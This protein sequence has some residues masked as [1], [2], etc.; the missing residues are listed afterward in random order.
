MLCAALAVWAVLIWMQLREDRKRERDLV[1]LQLLVPKKESK[2]DK[3]VESEQFSTGKDFREVLGVMDHLFQSLHSLYNNRMNRFLK[4]QDF[5]SVEYAALAGEILFFIVCPRRIAHLIEKQ[6]T[7]FYPD[8]IIDEVEDYDIF[9]ESSV[10]TA[11]ILVP[12]HPSFSTVIAPLFC[13]LPLSLFVY[14]K[15][16][17]FYP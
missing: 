16:I 12:H 8:T 4:G 5:I 1:F 10:A 3:E 11:D 14:L 15:D 2:E 17:V 6:I 13:T 7:A 9:T